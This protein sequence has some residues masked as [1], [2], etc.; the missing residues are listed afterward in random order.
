MKEEHLVIKK[1]NIFSKNLLSFI[2]MNWDI[3]PLGDSYY[4]TENASDTVISNAKRTL[5]NIH[6]S[7][8]NRLVFDI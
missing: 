2:E 8:V 1:L 3:T 6:I 4:E 5:R 7:N